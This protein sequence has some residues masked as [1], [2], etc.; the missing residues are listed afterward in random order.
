M[1]VSTKTKYA[2]EALL[3]ISLQKEEEYVS[4]QS[5]AESAKIS[6]SYL[7]QLFFQ[8]RKKGFLSSRRGVK[9]GF[10]LARNAQDITVGDVYRAMETNTVPVSCV[11]NNTVCENASNESCASR[12]LWIGLYETAYEKMDGITLAMLREKYTRGKVDEK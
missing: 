7:E 1:R 6:P 10:Y 5:V 12:L 4:I 3:Y 8:L 9:G 11:I 2:L